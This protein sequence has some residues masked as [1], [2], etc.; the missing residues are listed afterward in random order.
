MSAIGGAKG[1]LAASAV[2]ALV[3]FALVPSVAGAASASPALLVTANGP[4]QWAYGG[5]GYSNGSF[6]VG[7]SNL[8]WNASFGWTVVFT[9]TNTSAT[10][11]ELEEQRT[12]GI[13][14]SATYKGPAMSAA[15]QYHGQE[16]DTAFANLTNRSTVYENGVAVPALGLINDATFIS[17]AI[18]ES[19]S[20]THA[21]A[22]RTASLNVSGNAHVSAAFSPALGLIP[23]N[24]SG[25]TMW[26]SSAYVTPTGAWSLSWAWSNDGFGNSTGAGSGSANGTAGVAGSVELKG[27]QATQ[28]AVPLFSDHK[29]RTSV[30]LLVE[31]PL[32]N[33][34]VVYDGFV[35]TPPLFD[36]FGGGAHGYDSQSLGSASISGQAMFVSSSA[37]GPQITAGATTF[38][39]ADTAATGLLTADPSSGP[40]PAASTS[41][42][43]TVEGSPMS[44]SQAQAEAKCLT[45]GCSGGTS[46][47][48]SLGL[49]VV[50]AGLAVVAVVGSVAV[51][52]WRSYARRRARKGL[53]GGYA[54]SWP[55]GVPPTAAGP[56]PPAAMSGPA[57]GPSAPEMPP[58]QN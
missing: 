15:Y 24:L 3:A 1:W 53:V 5:M 26:N 27:F 12:V 35:L 29:Q 34:Y 33:Y 43:T 4:D 57:S 13:D 14:V 8:S 30:I 31:G 48:M 41:P 37:R 47:P 46:A 25:A 58:R 6:S 36:L 21:G 32:G 16:V 42:G 20:V 45:A 38:G 39:A 55:S 44:V 11:V 10:T 19:I 18:T 49:I 7:D 40:E 22:T 56:A 52:E 51:I 28:Y 54:E 9:E 23:L 50:V 17:G 2:A